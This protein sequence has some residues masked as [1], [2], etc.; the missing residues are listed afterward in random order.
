MRKL[1]LVAGLIF[2]MG[3]AYGQNNLSE[4]YQDGDGNVATVKQIGQLNVAFLD[5]LGNGNIIY[6]C[7]TGFLNSESFVIENGDYN[8]TYYGV[9]FT[10]WHSEQFGCQKFFVCKL[11]DPSNTQHQF[12]H[13][14]T[15]EAYIRGS[16]R[17]FV[18]QTQGWKYHYPVLG[19]NNYARIDILDM[20]DDNHVMQAQLY[21][22]NVATAYI[23][24]KSDENTVLQ[25][26]RGFD[27]M[28]DVSITG[29]SDENR[30]GVVQGWFGRL[31]FNNTAYVDLF[32]DS[33]DN[34]V[35]INQTDQNNYAEVVIGDFS[36]HNDVAIHQENPWWYTGSTALVSMMWDANYNQMSICQWDD[37]N[38]FASIDIYLADYNKIY[39][40]VSFGVPVIYGD[41]VFTEIFYDD[42]QF[43]VIRQEGYGE[44]ATI[45]INQGGTAWDQQADHNLVSIYQYGWWSYYNVAMIDI[46]ESNFNRAA[47]AQTGDNHWAEIDILFNSNG[48]TALISQHTD[49]NS[50]FITIS[51]GSDGNMS[52]IVQ[53]NSGYDDGFNYASIHQ[54]NNADNGLAVINQYWMYNTAL[55]EQTAGSGNEATIYQKTFNSWAHIFETGNDNFASICQHYFG[56]HSAEILIYGNGNGFNNALEGTSPYFKPS[57]PGY[58]NGYIFKVEN[59]VCFDPTNMIRQEGKANLARMIIVGDNNRSSIYQKGYSCG[60]GGVNNIAYLDIDMGNGNITGQYQD[61]SHNYSD[62]DIYDADNGKALTY[63]V[64]ADNGAYIFQY[65]G[66]GNMAGIDQFGLAHQG[67]IMQTGIGNEATINQFN[68]GH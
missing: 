27:N 56:Y 33:D 21:D 51:G 68:G 29:S 8:M 31:S 28:T 5:M 1:T 61:G 32:N 35:I 41:K 9:S 53:L 38:H 40:G 44:Y 55:I 50:A 59:W 11:W 7:Q 47:I 63:Q 10:P 62:I 66:D 52:N 65:N 60:C 25:Y 15:A 16:D 34:E 6:Q 26:Q 14:N 36:N 19:N 46:Y 18:S 20:S 17:N 58:H 12:G 2:V 30:V 13:F 4:V 64:G 43:N 23:S 3:F 67:T 48:N 49:N 54:Y 37:G 22:N 45:S 24:Y 39:D 42:Y 57:N